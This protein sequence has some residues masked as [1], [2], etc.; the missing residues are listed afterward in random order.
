V[1]VCIFLG[2]D[3]GLL[4]IHQGA[5]DPEKLKSHGM[6]VKNNLGRVLDVPSE[7]NLL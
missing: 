4:K 7:Q 1:S 5:C 3:Y 6:E 2:R